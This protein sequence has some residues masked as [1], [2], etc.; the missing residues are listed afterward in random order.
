MNTTF[1]TIIIL[2]LST[3][4]LAAPPAS[5]PYDKYTVDPYTRTRVILMNGIEAESIAR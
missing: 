2:L 4:A 1:V 3:L 5:Q